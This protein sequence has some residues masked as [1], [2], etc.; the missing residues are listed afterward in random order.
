MLQ[1][2]KHRSI[3]P[4]ISY[5]SDSSKWMKKVKESRRFL[6][7]LL[8]HIAPRT[9]SRLEIGSEP[10]YNVL[11]LEKNERF[12]LGSRSFSRIVSSYRLNE[13]EEVENDYITTDRAFEAV[14]QRGQTDLLELLI[15]TVDDSLL[16]DVVRVLSEANKGEHAC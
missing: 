10:E 16:Y 12:R 3:S 13:D 5:T 9:A 2:T 8:F 7:L 1:K 11:E 6:L 15:R 4:P 14:Q